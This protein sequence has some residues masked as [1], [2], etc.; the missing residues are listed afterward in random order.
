MISDEAAR[1]FLLPKSYQIQDWV[2]VLLLLLLLLLLF[3]YLLP[4]TSLYDGEF[5][6]F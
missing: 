6:V 5:S 3:I 1:V 4:N 2:L